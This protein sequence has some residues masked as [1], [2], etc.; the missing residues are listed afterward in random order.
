[1]F[2]AATPLK[3]Y[4]HWLVPIANDQ[5]TQFADAGLGTALRFSADLSSTCAFAGRVNRR[6]AGAIL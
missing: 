1:L 6:Q 2:R 4:G 5:L 3:A